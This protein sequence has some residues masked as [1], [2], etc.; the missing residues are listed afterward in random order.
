MAEYYIILWKIIWF[1][2]TILMLESDVYSTIVVYNFKK[3]LEDKY[4]KLIF[5]KMSNQVNYILV[6]Y[7]KNYVLLILISR[8]GPWKLKWLEKASNYIKNIYQCSYH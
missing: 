1:K 3:A 7:I 5:L 8:Q 6:Q 2:Y 4:V